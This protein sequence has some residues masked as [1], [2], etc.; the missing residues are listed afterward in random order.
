MPS[1]PASVDT[2]KR[3]LPALKASAACS[4]G[5]LM[6]AT[7]PEACWD[8]RR[9][10]VACLLAHGSTFSGVGASGKPGAVQRVL[11]GAADTGRVR[12]CSGVSFY[13][14]LLSS[15]TVAPD[16]S[17]PC[18][19]RHL[20]S[21]A[22]VSFEACPLSVPLGFPQPRDVDGDPLRFVLGQDLCVPRFGIVLSR[23]EVRERRRALARRTRARGSG[24][25]VRSRAVTQCGC[26]VA[27]TSIHR[28]N[29]I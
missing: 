22:S 1:P 25:A 6:T 4:R 21:A 7:R 3:T 2:R 15:P 5:W 8:L 27:A 18:A 13:R 23:V 16:H 17:R 9:K 24:A 10:L 20:S 11:P 29:S 28:R 19:D 14:T 12:G 26:R